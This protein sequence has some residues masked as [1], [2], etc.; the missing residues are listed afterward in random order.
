MCTA[1]VSI[2]LEL[3]TGRP[4]V[5]PIDESVSIHIGE[6]G[7]A[8]DDR[9]VA[10]LKESLELETHG[11]RKRLATG[12]DDLDVSHLGKE[13]ALEVEEQSGEISRVSAG[14]AVR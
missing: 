3:M 2:L 9:G 8:C 13:N 1:S 5:V 10:E 11:D 7:A 12:D 14:P 6:W 4:P